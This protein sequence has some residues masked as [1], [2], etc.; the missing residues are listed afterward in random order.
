[1]T[2][3]RSISPSRH[4]PPWRRRVPA[5]EET[6]AM[7]RAEAAEAADA[8]AGPADPE[9]EAEVVEAAMEAAVTE[10]SQTRTG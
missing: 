4:R 2:E 3:R 8:D 6:D 7:S 9:V 5:A 1:M 10:P